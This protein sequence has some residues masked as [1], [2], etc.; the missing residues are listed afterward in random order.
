MA[1]MGSRVFV[2]GGIGPDSMNPAKSEDN[3]LIHV[4]D[5]SK[6]ADPGPRY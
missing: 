4:L 2:L 3:T 6:C 1:S 5:T